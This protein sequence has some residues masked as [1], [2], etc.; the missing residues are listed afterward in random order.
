VANI[1]AYADEWKRSKIDN[2]ALMFRRAWRRRK[3]G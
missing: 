3:A 1:A 2:L